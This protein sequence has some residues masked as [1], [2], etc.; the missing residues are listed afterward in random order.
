MKQLRL[1]TA[2]CLIGSLMIMPQVR[3]SEIALLKE[4]ES[5]L[6]E[7]RVQPNLPAPEPIIIV[8]NQRLAEVLELAGRFNGYEVVFSSKVPGVVK[9]TRLPIDIHKLIPELGKEFDFAWHMRASRLFVATR[10]RQ[11]NFVL[12]LGGLDFE[13]LEKLVADTDI[14]PENFEMRLLEGSN[15]AILTGPASYID[16]VIAIAEE[17]RNQDGNHD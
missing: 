7:F 9:D 12:E 16:G 14:D 2:V 4:S 1:A 11:R 6:Q 15:T 13:Y 8:V 3:A 5:T 17:I 10:T